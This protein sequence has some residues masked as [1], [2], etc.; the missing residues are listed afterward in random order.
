M[1]GMALNRGQW[2]EH[3]PRPRD[4]LPPMTK[5]RAGSSECIDDDVSEWRGSMAMTT[6]A[7]RSGTLPTAYCALNRK[8]ESGQKRRCLGRSRLD[9]ELAKKWVSLPAIPLRRVRPAASL[10]STL[11]AESTGITTIGSINRGN[12]ARCVGYASAVGRSR[13]RRV[14]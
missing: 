1:G 7:C 11:T 14:W 8:R 12:G 13:V 9:I 5:F 3:T 4:V 10:K 2:D 6:V